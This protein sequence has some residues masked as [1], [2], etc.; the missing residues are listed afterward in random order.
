[1]GSLYGFARGVISGGC[2]VR[3]TKDAPCVPRATAPRCVHTGVSDARVFVVV[4][5]YSAS[6]RTSE[7]LHAVPGARA[8]GHEVE[9]G[10][11]HAPAHEVSGCSAL[12]H[13]KRLASNDIQTTVPGD[14]RALTQ[15]LQ[16]INALRHVLRLLGEH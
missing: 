4:R 2:F 8:V 15:S 10:H 13:R 11:A 1:M 14:V 7:S 9:L 16:S 12:L 5:E 6:V 3:I